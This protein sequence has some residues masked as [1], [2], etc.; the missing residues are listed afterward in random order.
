MEQ[1][2]KESANKFDLDDQE[3]R[4]NEKFSPKH[5]REVRVYATPYRPFRIHT[6]DSKK[7]VV[8][9][10]YNRWYCYS[11]KVACKL[12]GNKNRMSL[13]TLFRAVDDRGIEFILPVT[14]P[15][16]GY[17][18]EYRD[19]VMSI[20]DIATEHFVIMKSDRDLGYCIYR[21]QLLKKEPKWS[22]ET[23]NTLL[24]LAFP[25]EYYIDEGHYSLH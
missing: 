6:Q 24:D 3:F 19:S 4:N 22:D 5:A 15:W 9:C 16:D 12:W 1:T 23:F 13:A 18:F 10:E 17:S 7:A 8:K 25:G 11:N 21:K 2:K 20:I 14:E